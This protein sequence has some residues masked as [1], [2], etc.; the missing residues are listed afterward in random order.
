MGIKII[1]LY[2]RINRGAPG[3][4]P[5]PQKKR[6]RKNQENHKTSL[7]YSLV[8]SLTVKM[9]MLSILAKNCGEKEIELFP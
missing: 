6:L 7:N 5:P 8:P 1:N 2:T 3:R 9:K 4:P